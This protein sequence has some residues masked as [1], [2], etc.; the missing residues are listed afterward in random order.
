MSLEGPVTVPIILV[1][2]LADFES[3]LNLGYGRASAVASLFYLDQVNLIMNDGYRRKDFLG[4]HDVN[5]RGLLPWR[6][7]KEFFIIFRWRFVT[8]EYQI[9]KLYVQVNSFKLAFT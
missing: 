6:L 4:Y 7:W 8:L 9:L 3:F 1:L 5:F 2:V